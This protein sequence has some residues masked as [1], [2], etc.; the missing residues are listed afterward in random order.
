[1]GELEQGE[2][3]LCL[4]ELCKAKDAKIIDLLESHLSVP[5][6]LLNDRGRAHYESGIT[7]A[8]TQS[9]YLF[10]AVKQNGAALKNENPHR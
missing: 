1:M 8:D 6:S 10:G 9:N 5:V 2:F 4:A 7:F 3:Q